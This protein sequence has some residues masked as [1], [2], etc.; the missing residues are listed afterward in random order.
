[1]G[2]LRCVGLILTSFKHFYF[3]DLANG[4]EQNVKTSA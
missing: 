3:T 2:L 4:R 1:V